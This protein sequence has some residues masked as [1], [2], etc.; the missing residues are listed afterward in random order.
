[1]SEVPEKPV[2]PETPAVSVQEEEKT[3]LINQSQKAFV[4]FTRIKTGEDIWC[5]KQT[6][7]MG[8]SGKKADCVVDNPTVS[9]A[10]ARI[11]ITDEGCFI[12]D[13]NSTNHTYINGV[14]VQP[15][16]RLKLQNGDILKLSDE[17]FRVETG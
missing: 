6:I 13:L 12:E 10:H 11:Y 4:R 1:M 15:N 2:L 9:S 14:S 17:E 7:V 3:V 5:D 8:R 16:V